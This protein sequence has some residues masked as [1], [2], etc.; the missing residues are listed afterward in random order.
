MKLI[1][2]PGDSRAQVALREDLT[3]TEQIRIILS[4]EA[5][6]RG[7]ETFPFVSPNDYKALISKVDQIQFPDGKIYKFR[8]DPDGQLR[9]D[10]VKES[11]AVTAN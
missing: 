9:L 3:P 1:L 4:I 11:A 7:N 5:I 10:E 2:D 6:I 8:H